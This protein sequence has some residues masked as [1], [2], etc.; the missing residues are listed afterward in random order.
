[1]KLLII[2]HYFPPDLSAGSFRMQGLVTALAAWRDKGLEV[3]LITGNSNRYASLKEAAPAFEDRGWLR[4]H[5][6][7]L[8]AHNSGMADQARTFVSFA[9][10]VRRLTRGKRWD[11]VFATSSRLMTAALGAHIAR[12]MQSPLYLDI[13]D[14]FTENMTELLAAN[15]LKLLLPV[16]AQIE[17][18]AFCRA[19]HINVVS[20]GFVSR[21]ESIAPNVPISCY[22]NGID[23]LFLAA[24]FSRPTV[25]SCVPLILYAGNMGEGQGLHRVVPQ[26]AKA[27]EGRVRF[28]LIGDGG[29]RR[30]LE[31]AVAEMGNANIELLQ[32]VS[33][34]KLIAQYREADILFL[35]L[36]D[37]DAFRKVLPSKLFEYGATDKPIL[38][39]VDG[40]AAQFTT[41]HLPNAE[42]FAPCDVAGMV[43]AIER[44]LECGKTPDRAVFRTQFAR[45]S[46]MTEMAA[47]MMGRMLTADGAGQ[48]SSSG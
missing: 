14:L 9:Q 19:V 39:G 8:P 45:Q 38:A 10:G 20:E 46:I 25:D 7:E 31:T 4:I 48:S 26:A 36:N 13:R 5:R 18:A 29:K 15:P 35:H 32:P 6:L 22:S 21:I 12:R 2:T 1:M 27:L 23:D 47:D 24:D 33:R 41:T 43:A 37:L 34:D 42:V 40:F 11:L 30:E 16:F 3:D 28:R 44:L 17:R